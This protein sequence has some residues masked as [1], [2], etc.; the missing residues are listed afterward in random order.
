MTLTSIKD[1][2]LVEAKADVSESVEIHSMSMENGVMKM[3]MLESLDLSAGKPY[4]LSP[5]G[6]HL[7]LFDLKKP[8][9][10]GDSVNFVL[11]F[12]L[13]NKSLVKQNVKASVKDAPTASH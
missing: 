13:A 5:G 11:T 6:F 10:V 9:R 3:R 4:K 7:M 2:S 1:A 12:K 8:L